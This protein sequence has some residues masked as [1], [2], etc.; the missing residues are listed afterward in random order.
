MADHGLGRPLLQPQGS[1]IDVSGSQADF[2]AV[3]T[4]G[5]EVVLTTM[6]NI[7]LLWLGLWLTLD[8]EKYSSDRDPDAFLN[9]IYTYYQ[10]R[11]FW[12][13]VIRSFLHLL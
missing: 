4:G 7:S 10:Q 6:H 9:Q 11:G 12:N 5:T 2:V 8:D 13:S 1:V 3:D